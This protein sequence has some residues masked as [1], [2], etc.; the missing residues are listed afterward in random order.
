MF[1][2]IIN[3]QGAKIR[4]ILETSKKITDFLTFAIKKERT[5]IL[6]RPKILNDNLDK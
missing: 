2:F 4:I 1:R 6:V 3:Y 5:S